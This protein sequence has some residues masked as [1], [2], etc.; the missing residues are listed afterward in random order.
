MSVGYAK[1]P[2]WTY[3]KFDSNTVRFTNIPLW[4]PKGP[5]EPKDKQADTDAGAGETSSSQQP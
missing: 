3:Q 1:L 2:Q 5:E 4:K